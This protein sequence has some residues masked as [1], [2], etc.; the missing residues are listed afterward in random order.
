VV[1][2]KSG[3]TSRRERNL[4][5]E[6]PYYRKLVPLPNNSPKGTGKRFGGD[7]E[8]CNFLGIYEFGHS[9]VTSAFL[10]G[11]TS[12]NF[13][14]E[15]NRLNR[16]GGTNANIPFT[17]LFF[18]RNKQKGAP[19]G[20]RVVA[21]QTLGFYGFLFFPTVGG[22]LVVTPFN[23]VLIFYNVDFKGK[24]SMWICASLPWIRAQ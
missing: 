20:A 9:H 5:L 2:W 1:K 19:N 6:E 22:P 17:G 7:Y 21:P 16:S 15:Q 13:F 10:L 14:L 11:G 12:E 4:R 18:N 3:L 24:V 8:Y 23:N